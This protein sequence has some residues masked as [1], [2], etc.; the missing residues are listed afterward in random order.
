MFSDK[1]RTKFFDFIIPVI[2]FVDAFN[3]RQI[4]LDKFKEIEDEGTVRKPSEKLIKDITIF[5]D[6]MR[7]LNNIINEYIIYYKQINDNTINVDKL[8]ST[9]VYKNLIPK[10]F[11]ELQYNNGLVKSVFDKKREIIKLKV[12]ELEE[13][14]QNSKK[15]INLSNSM[16]ANS[17]QDLEAIFVHR[18]RKKGIN[19]IFTNNNDN[20]YAQ[21]QINLSDINISIESSEMEFDE[22]KSIRVQ[23]GNNTIQFPYNE[24]FTA[25]GEY[26]NLFT[27]TEAVKLKNKEKMYEEKEK[28]TEYINKKNEF[29]LITLKNLV[30]EYGADEIFDGI[31][32]NKL[33]VFLIK[34]GHIDETYRYYMSYFYPGAITQEG[35]DFLRSVKNHTELGYEYKLEKINE[36][37]K[38]I[39]ADEFKSKSVLNNCLI[40]YLL[41]NLSTEK[42]R[43]NIIF[44]ALIKDIDLRIDFVNQF[45]EKS[46]FRESFIAE[47][48]N[49]YTEFWD[50]IMDKSKFPVKKIDSFF[51]LIINACDVDAISALN[52]KGNIQSFIENTQYIFQME[53]IDNAEEKLKTIFEKLNIKFYSLKS[54]KAKYSPVAEL[55]LEDKLIVYILENSMF[56]INEEMVRYLYE[57]LVNYDEEKIKMFESK[58]YSSIKMLGNESLTN[59]IESDLTEYLKEVFLKLPQNTQED[60]EVVEEF[61]NS[62]KINNDDIK[63]KIINKSEI[64]IKN[65]KKVPTSFWNAIVECNKWDITWFNILCYF[66]NFNELSSKVIE[67]LNKEYVYKKLSDIRINE[68]EGTGDF[69]DDVCKQVYQYLYE[70][71]DISDSCMN[72]IQ[73]AIPEYYTYSENT[74]LSTERMKLILD[75][76]CMVP[77]ANNFIYLKNNYDEVY[78]DWSIKKFD[79]LLEKAK[80]IPLEINY[81][82]MYLGESEINS[83]NKLMLINFY[84]DIVLKNFDSEELI[85]LIFK[86]NEEEIIDKL[87]NSVFEALMHINN[88]Y[89]ERVFLLASKLKDFDFE[90]IKK[91]LNVLGEPL[92]LLAEKSSEGGEELK[93]G[94]SDSNKYLLEKLVRCDYIESF[95]EDRK[96]YQVKFN[97]EEKI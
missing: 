38:D 87:D 29:P 31:K 76:D 71:E 77:S 28:L 53:Y 94:K 68:I 24:I 74:R 12:E 84:K 49:I 35:M 60:V 51:V 33:L 11:S 4:V 30:K 13:K 56:Q 18:W 90:T 36:I 58:N 39:S 82:E 96:S 44:K 21:R 22:K 95:G 7:I 32:N 91:Y 79:K 75:N 25:F 59:Y 62:E 78:Y 23:Q 88:Y 52:R 26:D 34:E 37:I 15:L 27:M 9:I 50:F 93:I 66:E 41:N 2:P 61:L 43:L 86:L 83:K 69:S 55:K 6:D 97:I 40:K 46:E 67:Q 72:T 63:I 89:E 80:E 81:I 47:L 19:Y 3:S 73:D 70:N 42:W 1:D 64:I 10:D 5:L 85:K 92:N 65:L 57:Y 16:L 14:I 17:I 20:Y 54:S 45:C 8:F 48:C